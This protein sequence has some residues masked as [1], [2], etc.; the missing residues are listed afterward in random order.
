M[1]PRIYTYKITFEETP[2]WYWGV[3][4][5]KKLGELYLG[6]PVTHKWMWEF[7]TPR[8]QI[9]ELFPYTN[10]GWKEANLV[11]D[12]LIWPDLNNPFCLNEAC[13][14]YLSIE[15]HKLGG[16]KAH[17]VKNEKGKSIQ[18]LANIKKIH[19]EKDEKGRSVHSMKA[20]KKKDEKG[21]SLH[22]LEWAKR[23]Q[24]KIHKEKDELGRSIHAVNTLLKAHDKKDENGKSLHAKKVASITNSQLYQCL[25]TGKISTAGPLA[26]WQKARGIDPKNR[27]KLTLKTESS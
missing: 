24:E 16:K 10:E 25:E 11:E 1:K 17:E 19:V 8:V 12:R 4:K 9:L 26:R 22:A 20:H 14:T 7:Y 18:A 2:Y 6:S 23:T 15:S 5:E 3:H 27:V 13:G 21:R